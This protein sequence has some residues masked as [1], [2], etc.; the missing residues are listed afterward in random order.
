MTQNCSRLLG[1]V[2][3]QIRTVTFNWEDKMKNKTIRKK[4]KKKAR[5]RLALSHRHT[6]LSQ[7][8]KC[9]QL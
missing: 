2:Q 7:N 9:F 6:A 8:C 4:E 3:W 5:W 1:V